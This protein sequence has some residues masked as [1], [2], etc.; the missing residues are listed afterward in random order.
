[1]TTSLQTR[2]RRLEGGGANR[3]PACGFDGN[4]GK[5]KP[6][7]EPHATHDRN[8]Y[9]G[10]CGRLTRVVVSWRDEA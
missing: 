5:V 4:W 2:V 1:V 6:R 9:C 3:C 10:T 8:E 7:V